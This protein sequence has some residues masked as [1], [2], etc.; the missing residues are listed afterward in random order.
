MNIPDAV[1]VLER[2][3]RDIF[4]PRL[5]SLVA[6]RATERKR[7]GADA[8]RRRC[9]DRRR[10]AGVRR[11]RRRVAR[12][13]PGDAASSRRA[14]VRPIAGR[15]PARV[16]RDPRRSRGDIRQQSFRRPPRRAGAHPPRLRNPGAQSPA[17][18]A[19]RVRG[20]ARPWRRAGGS[21]RAVGRA[22]CCAHDE[23][24]S[25]AG[26]S[27]VAGRKRGGGGDG[28][29]RWDCRTGASPRS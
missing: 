1:Q 16:R 15:V 27:R 20:D 12:C 13:R 18:P 19:R 7:Y 24:R 28:S 6:Y 26:R 14:G 3:L 29:A 11:A 9:P 17:P 10:P 2:D 8:G 4:G 21:H 5:Q 25:S 23:R 22:V